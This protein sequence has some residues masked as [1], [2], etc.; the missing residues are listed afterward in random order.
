VTEPHAE[1]SGDEPFRENTLVG[2]TLQLG[3]KLRI[4]VLERDPRYKMITLDPDTGEMD[5]SVMRHVAQVHDG[6][7]GIYASRSRVARGSGLR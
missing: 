5:A 2:H 6:K 7:A 4:A 3:E 1:W